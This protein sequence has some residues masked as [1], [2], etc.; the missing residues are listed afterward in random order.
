MAIVADIARHRVATLPNTKQ[1]HGI[2]VVRALVTPAM[3][4]AWLAENNNENRH[5]AKLHVA[6]IAADIRDGRW[7]ENATAIQFDRDGNLIDGQ[8]RLH[9]V[10]LADTS[11]WTLVAYGVDRAAKFVIDQNIP[12]RP[13]DAMLFRGEKSVRALASVTRLVWAWER[14]V[15]AGPDERL[16]KFVGARG[17]SNGEALA[18][19][20]AHPELPA[21]VMFVDGN[22]SV[23]RLFNQS[24]GGFLHWVLS[25]SDAKAAEEFLLSVADG[26]DLSKTDPRLAL[27]RLMTRWAMSKKRPIQD[28]KIA[29]AI[30]A[31]NAWRNN[32][33]VM[34][35]SIRPSEPT[36]I[37]V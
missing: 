31:W 16:A 14:M 4:A 32:Q 6:A 15:A 1:E 34:L 13:K 9:A 24:V 20:D 18:V 11:I 2:N 22:H 27:N 21:S 25:T 26:A 12:K 3:A 29:C 19:L 17:M 33:P 30:K 37:P 10:V 7:I 8:H 36:P 28:L 5:I 23:R 35:L